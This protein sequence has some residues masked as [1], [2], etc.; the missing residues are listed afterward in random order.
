M[1]IQ[2][3][4][5]DPPV[6]PE[7]SADA[8][9]PATR[10]AEPPSRWSRFVEWWWA[11]QALA[12]ARRAAAERSPRALSA[13]RRAR[14][15]LALAELAFEPGRPDAHARYDAV[16]CELSRQAVYWALLSLRAERGGEAEAAE[17][18]SLAALWATTEPALLAR[19]AGGETLALALADALLG[20]DFRHFAELE[21]DEQVKLAAVARPFA[22]ALCAEAD[23]LSRELRRVRVARLLRLVSVTGILVACAVA[24]VLFQRGAESRSDLARGKPWTAS[25]K[26]PEGGCPSPA[27]SCPGESRYFFSTN[28]EDAPWF[29]VDLGRV[30]Q[31][32]AVRVH[33]REDC[34]SD[35]A[36][37]LVVE[38]SRDRKTWNEVARRTTDF[39]SWKASF[40]TTPARWVRLRVPRRTYLHLTSVR[41]LP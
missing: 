26:Y 11:K 7:P 4:E 30:E 17:P 25:S 24:L 13:L 8:A 22:A 6:A 28:E 19:A 37:P 12:A 27:Q 41:V 16:T 21:P 20:R 31:V 38:L 2:P 10:A 14:S 15:A 35:R 40:A 32:S 36:V 9:V 3:D 5:P 23:A 1:T 18:P 39:R 33:N 34:C 29:E